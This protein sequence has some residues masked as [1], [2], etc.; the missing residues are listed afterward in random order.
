MQF[1]FGTF[2]SDL[3][4]SE[5]HLSFLKRHPWLFRLLSPLL[6][7]FGLF[8][9]SFPENGAERLPWSRTLIYYGGFI[10][11][12]NASVPHYYTA[13][14]LQSIT[15]AIHFSSSAKQVLS[16]R[17]FLWLGRHSYAIYLI[18][19]TLIRTV[20]TWMFFGYALPTP[21]VKDDGSIDLGPQ[22]Q[23]CTKL[24][25]Y[26]R[27]PFFWVLLYA[28]AMIWTRWVDPSCAR[29]TEMMV[30]KMFEEED[31]RTPVRRGSSAGSSEVDE[32]EAEK[33]LLTL[34]PR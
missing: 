21:E 34:L 33:S 25:W 9:A 26:T 23:I 29:V 19:G 1:F 20:G 5:T 6:L 12:S 15:L 2:L 11:P 14:G 28:C 8:I 32:R 16:N 17:L 27:M 18:H 3:S 7:T 10:F 31:M 13:F 4:Q 22:L 30:K 24:K